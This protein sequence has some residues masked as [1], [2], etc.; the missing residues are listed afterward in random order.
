MTAITA[1]FARRP[2]KIFR[3]ILERAAFPLEAL[4]MT[5][6]GG[7][8]A[9]DRRRAAQGCA[10]TARQTGCLPRRRADP[11]PRCRPSPKPVTNRRGLRFL[12]RP[13]TRTLTPL[14]WGGGLQAHHVVGDL[15]AVGFTT[16]AQRSTAS[17]SAHPVRGVPVPPHRCSCRRGSRRSSAGT[18]GSPPSKTPGHRRWR[19]PS[20]STAGRR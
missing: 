16:P 10:A 17:P 13:Y 7:S 20:G 18:A 14:P 6:R 12:H 2:K 8:V 9:G 3:S 19:A 11:R 4:A 5:Y 1:V 15:R